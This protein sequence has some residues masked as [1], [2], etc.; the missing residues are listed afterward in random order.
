M[1]VTSVT[2]RTMNWFLC[3]NCC[4]MNVFVLTCGMMLQMT[5]WLLQAKLTKMAVGLYSVSEKKTKLA[6]LMDV[7]ICK[8]RKSDAD[9]PTPCSSVSHCDNT[10]SST[11]AN[12]RITPNPQV[13]C[14]NPTP[15]SLPISLLPRNA[16]GCKNYHFVARKMNPHF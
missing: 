1:S 8:L 14:E 5:N 9:R 4:L 13:N 7:I 6:G 12:W 16:C 15:Y 2:F 10:Q 11:S 3:R